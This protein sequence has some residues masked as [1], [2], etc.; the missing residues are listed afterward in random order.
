M[1]KEFKDIGKKMPYAVPDGF[2]N[3]ITA[4]TLEK[5]QRRELADRKRRVFLQWLVA[6][7]VL[8][9]IT[10]SGIRLLNTPEEIA[11][12]VVAGTPLEIPAQEGITKQDPPALTLN[13]I[14]ADLEKPASG[15]SLE[16]VKSVDNE[17]SVDELL[18]SI[19]DKEL[20]E[21]A[22]LMLNDPFSEET[23]NNAYH[24]DH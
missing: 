4:V 1:E 11:S 22:T 3:T 7:A 8:S 12:P 17:E 19:P 2:F 15:K 14:S 10:F 16:F 21:W 5:A 6:A 13:E 18:T 23:E 20:L 9:A 24:E